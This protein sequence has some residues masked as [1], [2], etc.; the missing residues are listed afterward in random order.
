MKNSD[1]CGLVSN[2]CGFI[3]PE[4][5]FDLQ[6]LIYIDLLHKKLLLV[7]KKYHHNCFN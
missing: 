2:V 7:Y 1:V 6:K 5:I 3:T 4:A